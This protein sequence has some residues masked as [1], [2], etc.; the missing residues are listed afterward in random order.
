MVDQW[1]EALKMKSSLGSHG[2]SSSHYPWTCLE[3]AAWQHN[4]QVA[5]VTRN[6]I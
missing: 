4:N 3:I 5:G 6:L 1:S 2:Q